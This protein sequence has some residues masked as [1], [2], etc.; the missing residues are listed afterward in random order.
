MPARHANGREFFVE[1]L[2]T[3]SQ[4]T[5]APDRQRDLEQYQGLIRGECSEYAVEKRYLRK[6]G[7]MVWVHVSTALIRDGQGQPLRTVGVVQDVDQRKR[8]EEALRQS[9]ER[10]RLILENAL[11]Y[12]IV[13]L[14]REGCV[15]TWNTG[16]Q[17][18]LGHD[19][20]EIVGRRL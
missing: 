19:E 3:F 7:K 14:D 10:Y 18:I 11:E 4:I 15:T 9:E 16:A 12:A 17:R 2:M 8:A 1:L 20:Q 13:T 6:D 5:V